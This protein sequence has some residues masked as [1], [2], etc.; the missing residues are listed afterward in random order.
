MDWFEDEWAERLAE[1]CT[2]HPPG[3]APDYSRASE[4]LAGF[5]SLAA[6]VDGLSIKDLPQG[7][8]WLG[9]VDRG[10]FLLPSGAGRISLI[11]GGGGREQLARGTTGHWRWMSS[12]G[13]VVFDAK[14]ADQLMRAALDLPAEP[15]P[16][17]APEAA[18]NAAGVGPRDGEVGHM[19][20]SGTRG[21]KRSRISPGSTVRDLDDPFKA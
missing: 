8:L 9:R 6:A 11:Y 12:A 15:E 7:G 18:A 3:D 13:T 5:R 1:S 4:L 14:A 16:R 21:F 10:L 2:A 19:G 20:R 17:K